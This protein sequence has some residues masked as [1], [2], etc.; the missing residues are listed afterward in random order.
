MPTSDQSYRVRIE[1][2]GPDFSFELLEREHRQ[3]QSVVDVGVERQR[4]PGSLFEL[5]DQDYLYRYIGR[6][7]S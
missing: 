7:L 2:D 4:G 1:T 6:A 5:R 3:L